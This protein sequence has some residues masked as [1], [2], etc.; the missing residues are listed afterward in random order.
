MGGQPEKRLQINQYSQVVVQYMYCTVIM[1]SNY[2]RCAL[3]TIVN[4]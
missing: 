2:Y 3:A 4:T 1:L